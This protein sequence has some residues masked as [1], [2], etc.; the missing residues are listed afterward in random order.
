LGITYDDGSLN[1]HPLPSMLG[2]K[3]LLI[4][5]RAQPR[6]GYSKYT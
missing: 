4:T 1:K 5:A 3:R 2:K 6:E